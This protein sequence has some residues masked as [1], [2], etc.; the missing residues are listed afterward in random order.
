[1]TRTKRL[2]RFVAD[3]PPNRLKDEAA[4]MPLIETIGTVISPVSPGAWFQRLT[5]DRSINC[6][7]PITR[8][9]AS[10]A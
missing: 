5:A 4:Y 10:R 8:D 3:P 7:R 6:R 9:M 1:M 2:G